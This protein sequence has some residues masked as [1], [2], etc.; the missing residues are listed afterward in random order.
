MIEIKENL[1]HFNKIMNNERLS[2]EFCSIKERTLFSLEKKGQRALPCPQTRRGRKEEK[3]RKEGIG[4][5]LSRRRFGERAPRACTPRLRVRAPGPFL[6][7][8]I[9]SLQWVAVTVESGGNQ[10]V[11]ARCRVGEKCARRAREQGEKEDQPAQESKPDP[12]SNASARS[13]G[14]SLVA[15]CYRD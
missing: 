10:V 8:M 1:M 6:K 13:Y 14:F 11:W 3:G 12:S 9:R 15:D 4:R 7:L 2:I 5:K